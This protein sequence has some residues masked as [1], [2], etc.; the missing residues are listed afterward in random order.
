MNVK[1]PAL[2]VT[3]FFFSQY[4]AVFKNLQISKKLK[5]CNACLLA[6]SPA[7]VTLLLRL[8]MGRFCY[9]EFVSVSEQPPIPNSFHLRICDGC[10]GMGLAA[11]NWDNRHLG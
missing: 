8:A 3:I 4:L 1:A 9:Q 2:P 11:V 7:S 6:L 5:F 10:D